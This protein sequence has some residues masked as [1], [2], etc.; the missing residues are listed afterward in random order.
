[1]S[2][3]NDN[4]RGIVKKTGEAIPAVAVI[5]TG[6]APLSFGAPEFKEGF[7]RVHNAHS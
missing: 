5:I 6:L 1:M 2:D 7:S 3:S 4:D